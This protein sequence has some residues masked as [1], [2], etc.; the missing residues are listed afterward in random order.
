MDQT[1]VKWRG[2][3]V[4]PTEGQLAA[5]G[6]RDFIRHVRPREFRQS[7]RASDLHLVIDRA[8]VNIQST[9]EQIRE[10][11]YV[12]HLVR[13]IRTASADDGIGPHFL[14]FFWSDFRIRVRHCK[15]QRIRC[16]GFN[17]LR[18]HSTL[19]GNAKEDIRALHGFFQ[20]AQIGIRRMR[21]FPLVHTF[22]TPLI[23]HAF[24]VT[25]DAIVMLRAHGLHEFDT[26]NARSTRAIQH[27]LHIFDFLAR[28]LKRI[29]KTRR[30]DHRRAVL[31]VVKDR[32][33]HL[34]FKALLNDETLRRFDVLKVDAAKG[35]AHQTHRVAELIGVF[36]VQLDIDRV[37]IGKALKQNRFTFHNRL[38]AQ[39]A[40]VP[41]TKNRGPVRDHRN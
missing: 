33:V 9:A 24:G 40:E 2:D 37:H 22:G 38:R 19:N 17:H 5:I 28:D 14:R 16:H 35:W 7:A 23:N 6:H 34:F 4:I 31:V 15:D 11:Q 30:T 10:S 20:S 25:N 29:Q 3:N 1:W 21:R 13:V 8:R 18:R 41:Q 36:G 26:G 12:V 27:D 32:N 39:R